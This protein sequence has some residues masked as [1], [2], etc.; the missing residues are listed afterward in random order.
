MTLN[1]GTTSSTTSSIVFTETNG[2]YSYS[3]GSVS[4]YT[5][6]PASGTV[7]VSGGAASVTITFTSTTPTAQ[8]AVTFHET[9]LPPAVE[10]AP[11]SS[12]T[13]LTWEVLF[14]VGFP[15]PSEPTLA[16]AAPPAR[17]GHSPVAT[18]AP[19]AIFGSS[20]EGDSIEFTAPSGTY[21]FVVYCVSNSTYTATPGSGNLTV[22]NA[23]V[24]QSV[25]FSAATYPVTF[26]ES[27]LPSGAFWSVTFGVGTQDASAG[28]S[29]TFNATNGTDG[30]EVS[31]TEP[32]Y[33]PTVS[34]GTVT[35]SGAA[36][37]VAVTFALAYSVTFSEN[38]ISGPTEWGVSLAGI[39][40]T[41][42]PAESITFTLTNGSY[43]F[44]AFA[45]GYTASPASGTVTVSGAPAD[46]MISFTPT[47][48]YTVSFTET[49][50]ASGTYWTVVLNGSS[51]YAIT[52][53]PIN[54]TEP[55]GQYA[56]TASAT[57]YRASPASGTVTVNGASVTVPIRFTPITTYP[58]TFSESGLPSPGASWDV[59]MLLNGAFSSQGIY[60]NSSSTSTIVLDVPNGN[61][62]WVVTYESSGYVPMPVAGGLTI[63]G[64]GAHQ[65]I[66]FSHAPSDHLVLFE[67]LSYE[68]TG[69]FGNPNGTTW[70]VTLGGATESTTGMILG[71][72]EPNGTYSY[73]ISAPSGYV[74][75]PAAGSLTIN[76]PAVGLTLLAAGSVYLVFSPG[77]PGAATVPSQAG[78]GAEPIVALASRPLVAFA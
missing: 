69:S 48:G 44:T 65:S 5:A 33:A 4:G 67:E 17:A 58:V 54:F 2:T 11:A 9:G 40:Q 68:V 63:L 21:F 71:F 39:E 6:S 27:G 38:G 62:T 75:V 3:V 74:A 29:I 28:S 76:W 61:Y 45:E 25:V 56:F 18:L 30:Y 42:Y 15:G 50:L 24:S 7:T 35:V 14:F 51:G 37:S 10:R 31:T 34:S 49:G 16:G 1:G 19:G 12:T 43:S 55:N 57:N 78:G 41:A 53:E 8:Y 72:A 52:G 47:P 59:E 64:A 22:S 32:G 66:T 70:S 23:P 77:G 26:T 46:E 13:S 20:G 73:T 36:V 60:F